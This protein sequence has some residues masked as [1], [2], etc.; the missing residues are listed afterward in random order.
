MVVVMTTKHVHSRAYHMARK[1]AEKEG[2]N[3]RVAKEVA[4]AAAAEAVKVFACRP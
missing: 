1:K 2:A 3:A 4:R